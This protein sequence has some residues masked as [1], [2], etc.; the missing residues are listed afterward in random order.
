MT[1]TYE[2]YRRHCNI[3]QQEILS[4]HQNITKQTKSDG[5]EFRNKYQSKQKLNLSA[6]NQILSV[7][8]DEMW[9]DVG[10]MIKYDDLVKFLIPQ[11]QSSILPAIVPE[12]L[13]ITVG[14]AISGVALETSSFKYGFVHDTCLEMDILTSDGQIYCCTPN[15]AYQDLFYGI[16]NSYGT[17]GYILRARMKLI[18]SKPFIKIQHTIYN[19]L[20]EG[21]SIFKKESVDDSTTNDYLEGI[22]YHPTNIHLLKGSF[23]HEVPT[24]YIMIDFNLKKPFY[25]SIEEE[26]LGKEAYLPLYEY[27]SRWDVDGFWGTENTILQQSWLRYYC[28]HYM[29]TELFLS[30]SR[31]PW[32]QYFSEYFMPPP[33]PPPP[34]TA[35]TTSTTTTNETIHY[36][37]ITTDNGIPV[38][39][40]E[41][42]L[43]W[44]YQTFPHSSPVWLCS[45]QTF[46]QC[47]LMQMKPN[48]LYCDF[49]TFSYLV[50]STSTNPTYYNELLEAKIF[51][52]GGTKCFYSLNC[53]PQYYDLIVN[54]EIY[55]QLKS[56]YDALQKFPLL[57]D[58]VYVK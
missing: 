5:H 48:H 35:A 43:Q 13:S 31:N 38:E 52:C 17:L 6:F 44:Y 57:K 2:E 14:G 29:K 32:F 18:A 7:N 9:I 1:Q 42:Y 41:D 30:L 4:F 58:K 23:I 19:T 47:P 33:P 10:G 56:K 25:K 21:L 27:L 46:S 45:I 40:W 16:P 50:P 24:N 54:H 37:K 39:S 3:V 51:A 15:N 20:S 26:D 53:N 8:T 34:P 12:L 49:G 28:R 22:I 36:E 55:L 11:Y